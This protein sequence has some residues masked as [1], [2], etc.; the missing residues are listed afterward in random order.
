[1]KNNDNTDA[2]VLMRAKEVMPGGCD[3]MG[4]LTRDFFSTEGKN[5]RPKFCAGVA[6]MLGRDDK[7]V[8]ELSTAIELV[9][10]AS[11]LQDDVFDDETDRRGELPF[12][13]RW[14]K[15]RSIL[16][17]DIVL[18]S[19]MSILWD[20]G[21]KDIAELL[22][23]SISL[24]CEGEIIHGEMRGKDI[25][26][27]DYIGIIEKKTASLFRAACLSGAMLATEDKFILDAAADL[28]LYFGT[29][30]QL[31]DDCLDMDGTDLVNGT[32]TLPFIHDEASCGKTLALA[33]KYLK[34]AKAKLA[35]MK[36]AAGCEMSEEIDPIL[37]WIEG[38]VS[39]KKG[40]IK[41]RTGG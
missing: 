11:I 20:V 1:M 28:G 38:V 19:A 10:R 16:L 7:T 37:E 4:K 36:K 34:K 13:L 39:E 6:R 24:M 22:L 35:D 26:E 40:N 41:S 8:L 33:G 15:S 29:A 32:V 14:A 17:S 2:Y 25:R 27:E 23:Y 12:H 21:R 30:Y 18:S 9:H 5:L 3:I 31:I